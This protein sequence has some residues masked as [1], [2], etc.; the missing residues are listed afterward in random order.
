MAEE[1]QP[2][3]GRAP[4]TAARRKMDQRDLH[5]GSLETKN[6]NS[7]AERS[8]KGETPAQV[9]P[10]NTGAFHPSKV[11][12]HFEHLLSL[13]VLGMKSQGH[14]KLWQHKAETLKAKGHRELEDGR[15]PREGEKQDMAATRRVNPFLKADF[16]DRV[17][18]HH[19]QGLPRCAPGF[20]PM[21]WG[22][23]PTCHTSG[24]EAQRR[25]IV[26]QGACS[27]P[28]VVRPPI[29]AA[30]N[31]QEGEPPYKERATALRLFALPPSPQ[32]AVKEA[33]RHTRNMQPP[34]GC[35]PL[36]FDRRS[37]LWHGGPGPH[38]MHPARRFLSAEKSHRR[39]RLLGAVTEG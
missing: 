5:A 39:S 24:P 3:R 7:S 14:G 13:G 34:R 1:R 17:S 16:P 37:N 4:P 2:P 18:K 22:P 27:R 36:G 8:S 9:L 11:V 38:D 19:G 6:T 35:A 31:G 21:T 12:Y 29:F 20:P 30:T 25:R 28:T 15:A 33:N 23:G 26:A 32:P 10:A